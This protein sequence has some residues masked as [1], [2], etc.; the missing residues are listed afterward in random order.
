[1]PSSP[2][3][4]AK[5]LH[6]LLLKDPENILM[7][8][9][10]YDLVDHALGQRQ[11][12]DAHIPG[13]ISVNLDQFMSAPKTGKNG[14]H[15]LPSR[16]TFIERLS[17]LGVSSN[18]MIVAYDSSGGF[19]ASRLWWMV[20]WVG[21]A[22][23]A[24][25]DGGFQSWMAAGYEVT[26]N[27]PA[28]RPVTSLALK[29]ALS[30]QVD[31]A[32]VLHGLNQPERLLIDARPNDRFQGKNETFDTQAGHIPGALSRPAKDNL[33]ADGFFKDRDTL[34]AELSQLLAGRQAH[35]V[36]TSC[37][38]GVAACHLLLSM[39]VAGMSGAALYA[40]SWSEWS[41]QPGAPVETGPG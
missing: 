18:T 8:D 36:V 7:L 3:I 16:E 27:M 32:D 4:R 19:Y 29:E 2:L 12:E 20:R 14:R 5:A 15:P 13:A 26:K 34:V 1:M 28:P 11:Y 17:S 33:N 24:V 39:E 40:G 31:F 23:V 30:K 22:Q 35:Q 38:S 10:R 25:L 6:A 41:A 21:H 37:G 9:C